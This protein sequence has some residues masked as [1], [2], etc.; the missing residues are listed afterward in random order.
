MLLDGEDGYQQILAQSRRVD[1]NDVISALK[2]HTLPSGSIVNLIEIGARKGVAYSD[3]RRLEAQVSID[4]L[5]LKAGGFHHTS[6]AILHS[7]RARRN[8]P[9]K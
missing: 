3:A 7:L 4:S 6:R 1:P 8:Q 5:E 2:S 9:T